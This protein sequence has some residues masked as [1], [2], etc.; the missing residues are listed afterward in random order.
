M[1]MNRWFSEKWNNTKIWCT[2]RICDIGYFIYQKGKTPFVK[3]LGL[4][5]FCWPQ[6]EKLQMVADLSKA[7]S[8]KLSPPPPQNIM[9]LKFGSFKLDVRQQIWILFNDGHDRR[10][11]AALFNVSPLDV[12]YIGKSR[13]PTDDKS[14]DSPVVIP[15][16]KKGGCEVQTGCF[17]R[18]DCN[19]EAL[20]AAVEMNPIGLKV[21]E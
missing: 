21:D 20:D 4:K 3:N 15:P 19:P 5:I 2:D 9:G 6:I 1:S 11:I 14:A 12:Y 18:E 10:E 7:F 8:E 17:R 13:Y 16:I